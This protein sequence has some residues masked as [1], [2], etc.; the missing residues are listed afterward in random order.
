MLMQNHGLLTVGRTIG[1]CFVFMDTLVRACKTQER[2]M[3]TGGRSRPL[4]RE[5]LQHTQQQMEKRRGNKPSGELEWRMYQRLV[6][7]EV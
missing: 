1:E 5:V 3:A 2:V 4:S 7:E 6:A